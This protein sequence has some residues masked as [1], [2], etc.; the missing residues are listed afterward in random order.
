MTFGK[1]LK[2]IREERGLSQETLAIAL[3]VSRE[4]ISKYERE[5]RF[6]SLDRA[7]S[8]AIFFNVS[9]LYLAGLT[10]HEYL[11]LSTLDDATRADILFLVKKRT[12]KK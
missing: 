12:K 2:K 1:R 4:T 3:G 7:I 9:L 5:E 10:D 6:P 8:I 11:D